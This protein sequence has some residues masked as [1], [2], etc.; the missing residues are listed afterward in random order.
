MFVSMYVCACVRVCGPATMVK[1]SKSAKYM[2]EG[3]AWELGL[4]VIGIER[5]GFRRGS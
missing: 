3:Y 5:E 1:R 4:N 2:R